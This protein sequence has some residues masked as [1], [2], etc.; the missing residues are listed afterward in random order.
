MAKLLS[1]TKIYGNL[2]VDTFANI[3]SNV[4][5]GVGNPT[6]TGNVY[7]AHTTPTTSSTTGALIVAGGAAV[8]GA[9]WIQNTGD[10]SANIGTLFSGNSAISA[11]LGAYQTFSNANAV[12]Q[13][14]QIT[15]ANTNIQTTS[16]NLGA[17]QTFSNANAASQQNQIT[18]ANT[19]IQTTSANLGA[20][21]TFAN[22]NVASLQNQITGANT[23]I[24][25]TSANL[26]AFEAYA[27]TKIGT[28]TNSN[29]VVVSA[30]ASTSN[31]TG[32]LVV[33][34]GAGISGNIYLGNKLGFVWGANNVSAVYQVF[35][36]VT[37]S[38]DTIFG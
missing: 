18:G 38:L 30:T 4:L 3:G 17:Y 1:G 7:I 12:S 27:N 9:V 5:V 14:N 34:G 36:P 35:N 25:T 32:A 21:Q 10:V 37:N 11:N 13:Q 26:G 2:Q 20:Y 19:N 16:A 28:N 15:G 23:N 33:T 29:L 22:A 24:Q 6:T 8:A 31:V